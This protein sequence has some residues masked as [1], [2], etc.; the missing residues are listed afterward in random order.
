MESR[1]KGLMNPSVGQQWKHRHRE[2][3]LGLGWGRRA[4]EGDEWR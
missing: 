1:K 4:G 3:T 2:Q